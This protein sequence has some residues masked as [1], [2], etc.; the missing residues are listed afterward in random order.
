VHKSV[1]WSDHSNQHSAS[2]DLRQGGVGRILIGKRVVSEL[3]EFFSLDVTVEA[4]LTNIDWK[5][6]FLKRRDQFGPKFQVEGSSSRTIFPVRKLDGIKISTEI[7]FVL[8]QFTGLTQT[9]RQTDGRRDRR[10]EILLT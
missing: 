8:S 7:S 1:H 10:A 6:T 5:S 3:I 4:L 2:T 9:D